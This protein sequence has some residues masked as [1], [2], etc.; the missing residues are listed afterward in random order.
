MDRQLHRTKIE[1]INMMLIFLVIFSGLCLGLYALY[2][3]DIAVVNACI[4]MLV[5]ISFIIQYAF[6]ENM[7]IYKILHILTTIFVILL[8]PDIS[9]K[10]L[11]GVITFICMSI[12]VKKKNNDMFRQPS[13]WRYNPAIVIIII[14]I[15]SEIYG[16]YLVSA[17]ISLAFVTYLII[18]K[19][20]EYLVESYIFLFS[21]T[22]ECRRSF[23]KTKKV[24]NKLWSKML[25][26]L[27]PVLL[28]VS[29]LPQFDVFNY[30]WEIIRTII[31]WLASIFKPSGAEIIIPTP[32]PIATKKPVMEFGEQTT[33]KEYNKTYTKITIIILII[34]AIAALIAILYSTFAGN[35]IQQNEED[36]EIEED[37]AVTDTTYAIP[38]KKT[39]FNG[40]FKKSKRQKIRKI[41][42]KSIIDNIDDDTHI[43]QSCTPEELCDMTQENVN[44][45]K[46]ED[47]RSIYE[48][49]RYSDE[50]ISDEDYRK[51][52]EL[53]KEI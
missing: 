13:T 44:K 39:V 28:L 16:N 5:P 29:L 32:K 53:K 4:Y 18:V 26:V 46:M 12:S 22:P 49:A 17:F 35:N 36:E 42:Y 21:V 15:I 24:I 30:V 40:V 37:D 25:A 7:K 9:S 34:L 48:K 11:I 50:I 38:K 52:K 43:N 8:C 27:V 51:M 45:G 3:V 6:L 10:L 41:F 31:I 2:E 1:C 23:Y 14:R 20:N 33:T 19:Y 47:M